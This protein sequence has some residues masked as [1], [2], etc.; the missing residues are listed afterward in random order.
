MQKYLIIILTI[1]FT[2]FTFGVKAEVDLARLRW[3]KFESGMSPEERS[4]LESSRQTFPAL[5]QVLKDIDSIG[6]ATLPSLADAEMQMLEYCISNGLGGTDDCKYIYETLLEA[7]KMRL[8]Y[9]KS[10]EYISEW[11]NNIK[12]WCYKDPERRDIWLIYIELYKTFPLVLDEEKAA[13]NTYMR[14]MK[15]V[16]DNKLPFDELGFKLGV[17]LIDIAA[18]I[19]PS[20]AKEKDIESLYKHLSK[21]QKMIWPDNRFAEALDI[22]YFHFIW[23][24]NPSN[25]FSLSRYTELLEKSKNPLKSSEA[26]RAKAFYY[27]TIGDYREAIQSI[28]EYNEIV[29]SVAKTLL[30]HSIE[31]LTTSAKSEKMSILCVS[32]DMVRFNTELN[33]IQSQIS[34]KSDPITNRGVEIIFN[35]LLAL[36]N[37]AIDKKH[38]CDICIELGNSDPY[39][40]AKFCILTRVQ[41]KLF[42]IGYYDKANELGYIIDDCIRADDLFEFAYYPLVMSYRLKLAE[43]YAHVNKFDEA[44]FTLERLDCIVMLLEG[45]NNTS[46]QIDLLLD[47]YANMAYYYFMKQDDSCLLYAEKYLDIRNLSVWPPYS[48]FYDSD[49]YYFY[50]LLSKEDPQKIISGL[51]ELRDKAFDANEKMF[52]A[53]L[54]YYIGGIWHSLENDVK[55][56]VRACEEYERAFDIFAQMKNTYALIRMTSNFLSCLDIMGNYKR[57]DEV[58]ASVINIFEKT[59][60]IVTLDYIKLLCN[61]ILLWSNSNITKALYH[62]IKLDSALQE[63]NVLIADHTIITQVN[64]VILPSIIEVASYYSLE[65]AKRLSPEIKSSLAERTT[66]YNKKSID[67]YIANSKSEYE[68]YFN[69]DDGIYCDILFSE[70]NWRIFNNEYDKADSLLNVLATKP[71]YKWNQDQISDFCPGMRLEIAMGRQDY[72]EAKRLISLPQISLFLNRSKNGNLNVLKVSNLHYT[73]EDIL[74]QNKRYNDAMEVAKKRYQSVRGFI[75]NQYASLSKSDRFSLASVTNSIDINTLLPFSN[76]SDNRILAYDASLFYRNILLESTNLQRD[77]IYATKDTVI[78]NDYE[79]LHGLNHQISTMF[80]NDSDEAEDTN[81][82]LK[83]IQDAHELGQSIADRCPA[84]NDLTLSRS[85]TWK[86]VAKSLDKDEAAIEFIS[87]NDMDT[88][89]RGHYGALVLRKGYRAPE[90]VSLLTQ[91]EF[92]Q[93]TKSKRTSS[94]IE[95]GINRIYSFPASGKELYEKLWAPLESHLKDAKRIYYAPVG[96]LSTL[97]FAAIEDSTRTTLCQKYD[98]RLVSSTAQVAKRK[99]GVKNEDMRLTLIGDVSYD[100]DSDKAAQRRG[101]WQHLDNSIKEIAYV[102]SLAGAEK[103][104]ISDT[105]TGVNASEE[106]F[107]SLSGNSP[108]ILLLST[109]GFYLDSH[110]ASRHDFYLNK[111]QTTDENPNEGIHPLLRGGIVLSDANTVW[112]NEG[113]RPDE[114]DGILTGEEIASLDLSN[115][116]L[117]VLSACET[118]LGEPTVTEGVNG[119]QR[120]FKISGVD[121]MIMSLWVVN[122]VAGADF[123][124][125]FYERLLVNRED[126][127]TAFRNTQLEMMERYPR[128]PYFWAPFVMLD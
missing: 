83:L 54:S 8:D 89:H 88:N 128:K 71:I 5:G 27:R 81:N 37:R 55:S 107:R 86:D 127:H 90:F 46:E 115:T 121:S 41:M 32:N 25:M 100:A 104:V 11:I 123:I 113:F 20:L 79:R 17:K 70:V 68:L 114:T 61:E 64:G 108:D 21:L 29:D 47:V 118:G 62:Y 112:N 65:P 14:G 91:E 98:L 26:L 67:N 18:K 36:N 34:D 120:G 22:S 93:C 10:N 42:G 76:N 97:A 57:H 51:T 124:K 58:I 12:G 50:T 126:R 19:D 116:K 16:K 96:S 111:G 2:S 3:I 38:L 101:S 9:E 85:V 102:D 80:I 103:K 43:Q 15:I 75:S 77:A 110:A 52:E 84:L 60:Q 1:F 23:R 35:N 73:L 59:N 105:I 72:T 45:T 95:N 74:Y 24:R 53:E 78:I 63:F 33:A 13:Q 39:N 28:D 4:F 82:K 66:I 40:N 56:R 69:E 125:R 106:R 44:I 48:K 49:I 7:A 109:H 30:P 6:Y 122:D 94:K 31:L 99:K 117:L 119:L 92:D 87:Y